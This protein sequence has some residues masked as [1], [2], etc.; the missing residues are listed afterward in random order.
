MK[1]FI[2]LTVFCLSFSCQTTKTV[3]APKNKK[4]NP[5]LKLGN[6]Y[7]RD[8]LLKE[9]VIEYRKGLTHPAVHTKPALY[10][11]IGII[12]VKLGDYKNARKTLD[13]AL[14]EYDDSF[15]LHFYKAEAHRALEEYDQAIYHYKRADKLKPGNLKLQKAL[16]WSYFK[17]RYYAKAL[18][19]SKNALKKN[20]KDPQIHL[21]L[22]RALIKT[23]RYR[24][25]G[26][27]LSSAK[28]FAGETELAHIQSIEG[29]LHLRNKNYEAAIKSY[30]AAL[31]IQPLLSGAL[32]GLGICLLE[33]KQVDK[34]IKYLERAMRIRPHDAQTY[35]VLGR[36]YKDRDIR[37]SRVFYKRFLKYASNDPEYLDEVVEVRKE[38]KKL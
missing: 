18:I 15:E 27:V 26:K 6:E 12:Q 25:A 1:H 9:A 14:P 3:E 32:R 33:D 17:I 31:K 11:N 5:H 4:R 37:K 20:R 19:I 24:S 34:S 2:L 28:R 10:R 38:L 36:A 35:L 23:H 21:I 7:A 29:D 30:R 22:A 13:R 16:A 8:G